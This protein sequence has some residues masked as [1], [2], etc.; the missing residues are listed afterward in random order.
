[1]GGILWYC[2]IIIVIENGLNLRRIRE[3]VDELKALTELINTDILHLKQAAALAPFFATT[4]FMEF[5]D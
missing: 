1:L 2:I 3:M 4:C 5:L